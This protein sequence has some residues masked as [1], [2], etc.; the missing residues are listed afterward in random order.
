MGSMNYSVIGL[1]AWK[2]IW[3]ASRDT[4]PLNLF[5]GVG[6]QERGYVGLNDEYDSESAL[7]TLCPNNQIG[8]L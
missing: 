1:L 2:S 4:E 6:Y 5:R 7:I 3:F 8:C